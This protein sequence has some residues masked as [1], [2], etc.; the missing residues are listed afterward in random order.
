MLDGNGTVSGATAE[1]LR[2]IHRN[3]LAKDGAPDPPPWEQLRQPYE[4]VL[5]EAR[6]R[7]T[8][9]WG[10]DSP[11][12]IEHLA[13][14]LLGYDLVRADRI[15]VQVDPERVDR[16]ALARALDAAAR[17]ASDRAGL[18]GGR[19]MQVVVQDGCFPAAEVVRVWRL[20]Q[21]EREGGRAELVQSY[22]ALDGRLHVAN[23]LGRPEAG[24]ELERRHAP[25]LAVGDLIY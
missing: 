22:V 11:A 6:R 15:L 5:A 20:M 4:A 17:E 7:T 13:N 9:P 8:D 24:D 3:D 23:G 12:A 25:L 19:R 16:A 14:G 1:Q 10:V 21:A 18:T 2:C